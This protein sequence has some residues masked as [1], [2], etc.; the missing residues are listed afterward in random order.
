MASNENVLLLMPDAD[1]SDISEAY[2]KAMRPKIPDNL[3]HLVQNTKKEIERNRLQAMI[4]LKNNS[5][6]GKLM[7]DLISDHF[8]A[9][10]EWPN[11]AIEIMLSPDFTYHKRL[12]LACF[13]VG[14]GLFDAEFGE[15]MFKFYNKYW[16][17]TQTWNRRFGEFREL[18]KYL[19][20]PADDPDS[21]RIRSTYFYYSMEVKQTLYF[22]GEVR[23]RQN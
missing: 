3:L 17:N 23:Y 1:D 18:F 11:Y 21:A 15:R 9:V 20:K 6:G 14:N 2:D 16:Q 10:H 4:R 13:M 7:V 12:A 19:N 22:N 5:T 8:Y